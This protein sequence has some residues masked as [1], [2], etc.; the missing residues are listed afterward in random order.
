MSKIKAYDQFEKRH[1][2]INEDELN[3]ML[4]T[5]KVK[6]LDQLIDQTIPKKY[7]LEKRAEAS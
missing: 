1:I 3:D 2:G 4:K 5:V 6:S 7:T